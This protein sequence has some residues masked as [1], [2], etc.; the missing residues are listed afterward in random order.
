MCCASRPDPVIGYIAFEAQIE[1][2][3]WGKATYTVRACPLR[4]PR[5]WRRTGRARHVATLIAALESPD[6]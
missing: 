1:P 6:A 2:I 4:F 5:C 3:E